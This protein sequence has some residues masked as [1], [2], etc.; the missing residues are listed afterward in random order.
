MHPFG[1]NFRHTEEVVYRTIKWLLKF[2]MEGIAVKKRGSVFSEWPGLLGALDFWG[3]GSTDTRV[4]FFYN[5]GALA[6]ITIIIVA[7]NFSTISTLDEAIQKAG[8]VVFGHGGVALLYVLSIIYMKKTELAGEKTK[9][10]FL[11]ALLLCLH[12]LCILIW[13]ISSYTLIISWALMFSTWPTIPMG[14]LEL[15]VVTS[16]RIRLQRLSPKDEL[17]E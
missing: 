16:G 17:G 2:E 6:I 3:S 10:G 15:I 13:I 9:N 7:W 12:L 11:N 5:L 1:K 8:W 4:P 14:I